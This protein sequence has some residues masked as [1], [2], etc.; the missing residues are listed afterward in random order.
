M[1]LRKLSAVALA[2]ILGV[3]GTSPVSATTQQLERFGNVFAL[4]V[5]GKFSMA[6]TA[7][8]FA[9]VVTDA[10]GNIKEWVVGPRL[11]RNAVPAGYGP[12]DLR[13]AYKVTGGGSSNYTIAIV[14]AYGYPNAERDLATY[15]SQYGLVPC[16]TANGCFKKVNQTGGT[17]PPTT[18]TSWGVEISLDL[19][20]ASA[21]CQN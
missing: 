10:R 21:I 9:K 3:A 11:T 4:S 1:R 2:T 16:T 7:H 15:R 5:C 20:M 13:S 6:G 14:D 12:A 18:N 19:D 8:C 17:T